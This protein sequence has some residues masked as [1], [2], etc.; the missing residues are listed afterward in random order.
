MAQAYRETKAAEIQNYK[1]D[2]AVTPVAGA[3]D[4]AVNRIV[5]S[6]AAGTIVYSINGV[7]GHAGVTLC[8]ADIGNNLDVQNTGI[9]IVE[10]GGVVAVNDAITAGALGRGVTG[11][12]YIIGFAL[13]AS[14]A[15]GDLI[16]VQLDA[17]NV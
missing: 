9:A 6:L 11:T 7:D 17:M 14:A 1:V 5:K 15:L 16:S 4:I 13:T 10:A 2:A 8:G 12:G 3:D